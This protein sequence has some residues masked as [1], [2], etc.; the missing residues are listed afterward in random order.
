MFNKSN[1]NIR[2][3]VSIESFSNLNYH[4]FLNFMDGDVFF[5]EKYNLVGIF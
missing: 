2:D 5:V 1:S 3:I 4:R